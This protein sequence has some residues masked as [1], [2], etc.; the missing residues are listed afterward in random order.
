MNIEHIEKTIAQSS[1]I[2]P[3]NF[4]AIRINLI[5]NKIKFSKKFIDEHELIDRYGLDYG[6]VE[7]NGQK[8]LV[9]VKVP[10]NVMVNG[11]LQYVNPIPHICGSQKLK[12]K[13][14]FKGSVTRPEIVNDLYK[15]I[16]PKEK[17]VF[18]FDIVLTN[19]RVVPYVE[20]INH[21]TKSALVK[22]NN[23][24]VYDIVLVN[25]DRI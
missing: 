4:E 15:A 8:T 9:I 21:K 5:N 1:T 25:I 7:E 16:I 11:N 19:P 22:R 20:C 17:N 24:E 6:L 14:G 2:R 10:L 3:Q 23:V 18:S 12:A 13:G